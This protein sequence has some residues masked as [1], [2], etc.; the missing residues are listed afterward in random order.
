ME[1]LSL[2]ISTAN[3]GSSGTDNRIQDLVDRVECIQEKMY[4]FEV[5][6][7]NNLLFYGI[8]EEKKET[9]TELYTKVLVMKILKF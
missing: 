3:A 1:E 5:N 6:K 7:R 9:P 4:D 2:K 8:R